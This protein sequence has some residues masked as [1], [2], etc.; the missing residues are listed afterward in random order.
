L[1]EKTDDNDKA[2]IDKNSK[3]ESTVEVG[4]FSIIGKEVKIG[5]N[6]KILSHVVIAETHPYLMT[7]RY[8]L[9]HL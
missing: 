1:I 3:L 9:L 7:V 4:P 2:I 8:T 6:V 5:K